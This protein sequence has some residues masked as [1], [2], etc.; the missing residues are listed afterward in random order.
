MYLYM[1]IFILSDI[2]GYVRSL[3]TQWAKSPKKKKQTEGMRFKI[4]LFQKCTPTGCFFGDF[5]HWVR[6]IK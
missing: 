4:K 6:E 2:P 3:I 1:Y 5:A